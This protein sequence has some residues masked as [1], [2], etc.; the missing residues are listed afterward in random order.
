MLVG[1]RKDRRGNREEG[2]ITLN[3]LT[4]GGGR[5]PLRNPLTARKEQKTYSVVNGHLAL[6]R[7]EYRT[8]L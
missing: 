3:L 8:G 5:G 1:E 2:P 7:G 6:G 4:G